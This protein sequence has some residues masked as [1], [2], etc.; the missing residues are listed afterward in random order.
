MKR[1]ELLLRGTAVAVLLVGSWIPDHGILRADD[2]ASPG[3]IDRLER[4]FSRN[5]NSR[6]KHAVGQQEA[7]VESAA[8]I[9]PAAAEKNMFSRFWG[10][11]RGSGSR[12][13]QNTTASPIPPVPPDYSPPEPSTKVRVAAPSRQP[14]AAPRAVPSGVTEPSPVPPADSRLKLAPARIGSGVPQ[15][16]NA[17]EVPEEPPASARHFVQPGPAPGFMDGQ[18]GSD[19]SG[20]T[21]EGDFLDVDVINER[22]QTLGDRAFSGDAAT[23]RRTATAEPAVTLPSHE[24]AAVEQGRAGLRGPSARTQEDLF[25]GREPA[26]THPPASYKSQTSSNSERFQEEIARIEEEQ[27][28]RESRLERI[29]TR[30]GLVGFKGFCPVELRDR[31][32]LVD[33]DPRI[34]TRFDG[35]EYSFSSRRALRQFEDDPM[36]YAPANRGLD[37][38]LLAEGREVRGQ[39]DYALWFRNRLYLFSS[40]ESMA[41]F[42]S[43]PQQFAV[44]GTAQIN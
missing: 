16:T 7:D 37:A 15:S 20:N 12:P 29:R 26:I 6:V 4:L 11:V 28:S 5:G 19:V 13:Q 17:V 23:D 39:L 32:D 21:T 35:Q 38:V 3:T 27:S 44:S 1:M 14:D 22:M 43:R 41:R 31:K 2:V 33:A 36:R 8:E 40:R 25:A 34:T 10:S 30:E 24:P 9:R 18:R 42:N